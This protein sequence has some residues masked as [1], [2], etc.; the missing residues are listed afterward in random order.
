VDDQA[1]RVADIITELTGRAS[2][3]DAR[4]RLAAWLKDMRHR[5][6]ALRWLRYVTDSDVDPALELAL[7][8][9]I[10]DVLDGIVRTGPIAGMTSVVRRHRRDGGQGG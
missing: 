8:T 10:Q 9:P 2:D 3:G 7:R 1:N 5:D 6:V 4:A